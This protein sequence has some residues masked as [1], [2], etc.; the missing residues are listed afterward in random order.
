MQV[1]KKNSMIAGGVSVSRN[2]S[3]TI[4]K[5]KRMNRQ[6]I[7]GVDQKWGPNVWG[8]RKA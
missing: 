8:M 6:G 2:T 3:I 7:E 4:K 1:G 5:K